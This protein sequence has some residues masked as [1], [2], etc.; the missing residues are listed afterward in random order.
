M[1]YDLKPAGALGIKAEFW[2]LLLSVWQGEGRDNKSHILYRGIA[3]EQACTWQLQGHHLLARCLGRH[4]SRSGPLFCLTN[5]RAAMKA[6][7]CESD[8]FRQLQEGPGNL[9]YELDFVDSSAVAELVPKPRNLR[10]WS[11]TGGPGFLD[12]EQEVGPRERSLF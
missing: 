12:W 3:L 6:Q 11:M 4:C 5:T 2:A 1:G 9:N 7:S 10:E 8:T